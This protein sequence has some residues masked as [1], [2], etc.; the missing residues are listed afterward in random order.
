MNVTMK[1]TAVMVSAIALA[2]LPAVAMAQDSSGGIFGLIGFFNSLFQELQTF[3]GYLLALMGIIAMG[4][5]VFN[6]IQHFKVENRDDPNQKSR[7]VFGLVSF[8]CGVFLAG[9]AYQTIGANTNFEEGTG[10]VTP[11]PAVVEHIAAVV[12]Q[13]LDVV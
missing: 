13:R 3:F 11:A 4:F 7:L 5:G 12:P 2:S 8:V 9:G 6:I 10:S 1:R